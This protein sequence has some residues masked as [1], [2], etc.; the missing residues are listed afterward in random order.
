MSLTDFTVKNAKA[1]E[2]VYFLKDEYGLSLYIR[3]SGKKSWR[4]RYWLHVKENTV[5]LG[6]YPLMGLREARE[7]RDEARKSVALGV[8]PEVKTKEEIRTGST[9]GDI[10]CE[11]LEMRKAEYK[12]IKSYNTMESRV[13]RYLLPF[14]GNLLPD[15]ITA[16]PVAERYQAHRGAGNA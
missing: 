1:K 16:P 8:K 7:R 9:F 13:K 4:L 11:F 10:C 2:N 5:T 6:E 14:L 12:S 3:P 15:E